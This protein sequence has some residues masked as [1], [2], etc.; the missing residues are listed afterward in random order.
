MLFWSIILSF[1]VNNQDD[2]K[3]LS[4]KISQCTCKC[5]GKNTRGNPSTLAL[6]ESA[7]VGS[8]LLIIGGFVKHFSSLYC[9]IRL[10]CKVVLFHR[11]FSFNKRTTMR[12]KLQHY[13]HFDTNDAFVGNKRFCLEWIRSDI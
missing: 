4:E 13:F 2:R 12:N 6:N 9:K 11:N 1:I 10:S 3:L 7:N 5:N 8:Q